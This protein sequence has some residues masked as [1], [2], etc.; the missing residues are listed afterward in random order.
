MNEIVTF[1]QENPVQYL[2]TVGRDGKAMRRLYV[3]PGSW[4]ASCGFVPTMKK[5]SIR[6]CGPIP[7]LRYLSPA[8]LMRGLSKR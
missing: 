2:A 3:Q 8:P 5:R 4:T 6:R 7:A 1:L